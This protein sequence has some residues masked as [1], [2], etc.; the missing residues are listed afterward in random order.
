MNPLGAF[1]FLQAKSDK[2]VAIPRALA[3][4]RA[5][6]DAGGRW[7]RFASTAT[8]G[9]AT[10]M[11]TNADKSAKQIRAEVQTKKLLQ[12]MQQRYPTLPWMGHPRQGRDPLQ[13]RAHRP[14]GD[15]WPGGPNHPRVE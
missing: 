14:L 6:Q 4:P 12:L 8:T 10:D 15:M 3:L 11:F 7:K 2:W 5:L 9:I 1:L 13:H